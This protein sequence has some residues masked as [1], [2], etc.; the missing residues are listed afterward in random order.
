MPILRHSI[1]SHTQSMTF[2]LSLVSLAVLASM[3][4][5]TLVA[6]SAEQ[7]AN[8]SDAAFTYPMLADARNDDWKATDEPSREKSKGQYRERHQEPAR[9]RSKGPARERNQQPPRETSREP[10][11]ERY[12]QPTRERSREPAR[13]R[14]QQP[15][16]E[17]S[18][19]PARER[20]QQPP[21]ERSREPVRERYQ[22]PPRVTIKEPVRERYQEPYR[23]KPKERERYRDHDRRYDR[24]E[25]VRWRE[26]HDDRRYYKPR[27]YSPAPRGRFYT[28][29]RHYRS[30]DVVI[31]QPFR[32]DYP[33]HHRYYHLHNDIWGWLSFTAITL[34][35]LDNLN[36]QQQRAHEMALYDATSAP[37]GETIYWR[38]GN[39]SGSVT[40]IEDGTSSSGRYCREFQNEVAIGG[41]RESLYGTACQNSDGSWEIVQ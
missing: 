37:L 7:Q 41:K 18:R 9:E 6:G 33:R 35:I 24:D 11:R 27:Y 38:D 32:Y 5:E 3:L 36:D 2:R 26:H 8:S 28:G 22:A 12:Q 30:H 29:P 14:H 20:H 23:I 25:P 13:E 10:A 17:R 21:R 39:A 1:K 15:P 31:V 19:E 40:P 16:R 34:A 4:G